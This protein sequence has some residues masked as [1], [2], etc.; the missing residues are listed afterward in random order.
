VSSRVPASMSSRTNRC[1]PIAALRAGEPD[2]HAAHR[3]GDGNNARSRVARS[4][5][6]GPECPQWNPIAL[7]GPLIS[8]RSC[9]L[10]CSVRGP[11]V[12]CCWPAGSP[13][14][15]QGASKWNKVEH[16]L[17]SFVS[18]NW[19]GA[20]TGLQDDR[21]AHRHDDHG[22]VAAGHVPVWTVGNTHRDANPAMR[23][24]GTLPSTN[25]AI[26]V[27]PEE[28]ILSL[29]R[30]LDSPGTGPRYST[31]STRSMIETERLSA[32]V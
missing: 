17:F 3:R 30:P 20:G 25:A 14:N 12:R 2:R 10:Q 28:P 7:P 1:R 6:R 21:P 22:E 5:G 18:S 32:G 16:R 15:L 8:R 11:R 27:F 19:R 26:P 9:N 29:W 24:C 23:G 31:P 13:G 4:P